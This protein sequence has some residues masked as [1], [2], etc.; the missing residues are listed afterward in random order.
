MN[1]KLRLK[2]LIVGTIV[3][4]GVLG[5]DIYKGYVFAGIIAVLSLLYYVPQYID[6][7]R[8]LRKDT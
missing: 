8:K 6:T 2:L 3:I 5:F 1:P 7:L 4:V